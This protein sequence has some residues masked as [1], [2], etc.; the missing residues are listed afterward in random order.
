MHIYTRRKSYNIEVQIHC[1]L[2]STY[3]SAIQE[4]CVSLV[5]SR[6]FHEPCNLFFPLS[7]SKRG[8]TVWYCKIDISFLQ[9]FLAQ[10][11]S[12]QAKF[13]FSFEYRYVR[14]FETFL[15]R[16]QF[17]YLTQK[18]IFC[19]VHISITGFDNAKRYLVMNA[20]RL[21]SI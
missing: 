19:V 7:A 21:L 6:D 9:M 20:C 3:Q 12:L 16:S 5:H 17:S 2:L 10:F 8:H 18:R 11:R 13:C 14:N 1:A 15:S 4:N